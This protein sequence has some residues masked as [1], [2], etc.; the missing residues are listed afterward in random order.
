MKAETQSAIARGM[1]K[2][3]KSF[4]DLWAELVLRRTCLGFVSAGVELLRDHRSS[5]ASFGELASRRGNSGL[6]YEQ[7]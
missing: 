6:G 1:L 5:L 7:R 2:K 4:T 3:L